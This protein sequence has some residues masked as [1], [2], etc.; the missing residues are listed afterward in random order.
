MD[1]ALIA[2]WNAKVGQLDR[3]FHL[4]DFC[5]TNRDRGQRIFNRLNGQKHLVLGNHDKTGRQI[6]GWNWVHAYHE[7]TIDKQR[8]VLCH[9]AMRVFNRV[10]HGAIQLYG[11]SHGRLPGNSQQLDVGVDCWDYSPVNLDD[12]KRRLK[13]LPKWSPLDHHGDK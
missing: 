11:H 6:K 7:L 9:Y 4:G 3:V 10:H 5:M 2:N 13:T 12:I 1:E 8:I